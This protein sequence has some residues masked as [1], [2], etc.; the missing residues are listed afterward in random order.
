[1]QKGS[2]GFRPEV[3]S[4]T[5]RFKVPEAYLRTGK[6]G[7]RYVKTTVAKLIDAAWRAGRPATQVTH[8]LKGTNMG[9]D[10]LITCGL[11]YKDPE[12]QCR[13]G[14]VYSAHRK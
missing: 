4:S 5:D 8:K 10:T 7:R 14:D 9:E 3:V 12:R 1:V 6:D 2:A 11:K 13:L